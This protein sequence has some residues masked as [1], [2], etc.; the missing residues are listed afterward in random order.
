MQQAGIRQTAGR[1]LRI[2]ENDTAE[3]EAEQ[4]GT[5]IE[6]GSSAV[7]GS[8]QQN[9]VLQRLVVPRPCEKL[10]NCPPP[11]PIVM[12]PIPSCSTIP[13]KDM[14][15][16][17]ARRYVYTQ[18]NPRASLNVRSIDCF[19]GVGPCTIE[20]DSGIAVSADV[21]LLDFDPPPGQGRGRIF[22]EETV[23]PSSAN[24]L[25]DAAKKQFGPRCSWDVECVNGQ[26][27]WTFNGC[28]LTGL[29]GPGDFP[30]PSGDTQVA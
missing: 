18:L 23:P 16:E 20:F 7:P 27:K 3:H 30:T 29:L 25:K 2:A 5:T 19:A 10:G 13:H 14:M 6:R 9:P 26:I 4:M 17:F 15:L 8:V 24:P 21:L 11:P 12:S 1:E 22:V 28:R